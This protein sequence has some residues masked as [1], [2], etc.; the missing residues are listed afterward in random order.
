MRLVLEEVSRPLPLR[1][2]L[3]I[4]LVNL[5]SEPMDMRETPQYLD[6]F[7]WTLNVALPRLLDDRRSLE[8]FLGPEK[9]RRSSGY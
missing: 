2:A 9:R 1:D 7:A 3:D 8:S 6:L 4:A 5:A